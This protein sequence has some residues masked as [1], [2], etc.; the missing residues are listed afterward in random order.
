MFKYERTNENEQKGEERSL[1][2][3]QEPTR[4]INFNLTLGG[5]DLSTYTTQC[6]MA[7]KCTEIFNLD[8]N[9]TL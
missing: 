1:R 6:N 8:R 7:L 5:L 3:N 4:E 9:L 2:K